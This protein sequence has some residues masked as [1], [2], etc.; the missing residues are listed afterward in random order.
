MRV[1]APNGHVADGEFASTLGFTPFRDKGL[2]IRRTILDDIVLRG[3][4]TAGARVQEGTRVTDVLTDDA[5]RVSGVTVIN[6]EGKT[7][8]LR[9]RFVVGADGLRSIVGRRLG[10]VKTS[11]IWPK[12]IA[13]VAHY[14]GVQG[15]T[16]MGEIR[17]DSLASMPTLIVHG[18]KDP[19]IPTDCSERLYEGLKKHHKAEL[20]LKILNDRGHD[21]TLASDDGLTLQFLDKLSAGQSGQ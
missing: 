5:G 14:R 11:S 15:V 4:K 9:A 21:I 6:H 2:A 18:T 3:A 12:R 16:D 13:L 20:S 8:E 1:R 17:Y 10:L 7:D 19:I